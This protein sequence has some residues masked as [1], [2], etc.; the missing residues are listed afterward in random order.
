MKYDIA[1]DKTG[2]TI[3][4]RVSIEGAPFRLSNVECVVRECRK[5]MNLDTWADEHALLF[6]AD[7]DLNLIGWFEV[8]RG[9]GSSVLVDNRGILM[10]SLLLG[11][12][13]ILIV[14]NHPSG[15]PALS[16]AD[17]KQAECLKR[18]CKAVGITFLDSLV[19][20]MGK[21]DGRRISK[22]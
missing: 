7:S 1:L 21:E 8:G 17:K 14:H 22:R 15:N 16:P 5:Q 20:V 6:C 9:T 3:L 10:R 13:V 4:N 12:Q 18:G 11:A 19:I 2:R